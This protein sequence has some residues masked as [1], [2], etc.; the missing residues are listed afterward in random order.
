MN[1][2][3]VGNIASG[4]TTLADALC[5]KIDG[6]RDSIDD[7]RKEVSNGSFSGEF[8]A[9]AEMLNAI[10]HPAPNTHA[11]YEFSGTG[12]NAWFVSKCIQS[13][14]K[15][16]GSKWM[17]VYCLADRS[18]LIERCK[19]RVYDIPLPYKL[20]PAVNSIDY[21]GEEL[22]KNFGKSFWNCPEITVRTDQMTPDEAADYII[23]K[24]E[25]TFG[26]KL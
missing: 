12:K 17:T 11:A 2:L 20:G 5:K 8:Q 14:Q 19:D 7:Y 15:E 10:E 24:A 22:K 3:F 13:S 26:G 16:H 21:M 25:E 9:W 18:V 4:K 23:K 6:I 1:F